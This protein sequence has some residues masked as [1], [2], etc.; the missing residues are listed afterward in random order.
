MDI[1]PVQTVQAVPIAT[2]GVGFAVSRVY[3]ALCRAQGRTRVDDICT[4]YQMYRVMLIAIRYKIFL[5]HQEQQQYQPSFVLP[6]AAPLAE[7]VR[8]EMARV[9]QFPTLLGCIVD[10]LGVVVSG[11]LTYTH[12]GTPSKKMS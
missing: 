1:N 9:S 10:T 2:R 7:E 4:I 8:T 3:E 11:R 12:A 5:A 6:E